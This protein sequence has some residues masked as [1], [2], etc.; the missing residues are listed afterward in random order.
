MECPACQ[1]ENPE[2]VK[3]IMNTIFDGMKKVILKSG[4]FIEHSTGDSVLAL[5]GVPKVS[6]RS[7]Q[8]LVELGIIKT[9]N[10][11]EAGKYD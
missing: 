5:F 9:S 6:Y 2:D 1:R 3:S 7:S 8:Q 10:D 11:F 4:G